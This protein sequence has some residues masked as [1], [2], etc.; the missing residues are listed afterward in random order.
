MRSDYS[1][2]VTQRKYLHDILQDVRLLDTRSSSIPFPPTIHLTSD[3]GSLLPDPSPY[4]RLVGR[5]LHLGFSRPNISFSVQQLSQY[6]QHLKS[7]HWDATSHLRRYLKSSSSTNIFF[8]SQNSLQLIASL[9][10]PGLHV[11]IFV[12]PLQVSAFF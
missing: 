2:L 6:I 12:T 11:L 9:M 10:S 1:L 5:L 4:R 8:P 7:I 3:A